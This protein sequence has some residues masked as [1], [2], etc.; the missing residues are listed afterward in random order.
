MLKSKVFISC[1][2]QTEEEKSIGKG[3]VEY[4]EKR[5]FDPYFAEEVHS[6][7]G[8]TENI[9][10]NLGSCEYFIA[11][12]F[13]RDDTDFGSLFVQQELAIASYN[14]TQLLAFHMPSIKLKG[15]V[16]YLHVNSIK[17]SSLSDIIRSL[18]RLTKTW[19]PNSK[20]ILKLNFGNEH[21][22]VEIR[23]QNNILSNWYHVTVENLSS[24]F[25]ARNCYAFVDSIYDLDSKK[26]VFSRNEYK[27]E[28]VWSGT[29]RI[30]VNI[31][32]NSKKD[33]DAIYTVHRSRQW[34]FQEIN[35]STLYRYPTLSDG[36]YKITYSILSDN[37]STSKIKI[38]VKLEND[39]VNLLKE[40]QVA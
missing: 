11:I 1:G 3:I 2:Q 40:E 38:Y 15:V 7:L 10:K 23:N 16:K 17:F 22:N 25:T 19:D 20:N 29:G 26:D 14:G 32:Y 27:N 30:S 8:L 13:K 35:T 12:N 5:G 24:L 37:F 39:K 34:T 6:P 18:D 33:I 36:H 31:P 9:Y 21:L 28:L 4:F